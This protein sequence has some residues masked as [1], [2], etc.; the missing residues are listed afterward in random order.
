MCSLL[1]VAF[2]DSHAMWA[3]H[4][5]GAFSQLDLRYSHKPLDAIPRVAATWDAAGSLAF[6][7]DRPRRWE[8]PYDDLYVLTRRAPRTAN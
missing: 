4:S 1:D 6:V 3:Q 2:A 8:I 5:T 7:T